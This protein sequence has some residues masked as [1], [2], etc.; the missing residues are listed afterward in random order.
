M[1]PWAPQRKKTGCLPFHLL[2]KKIESAVMTLDQPL[3]RLVLL[4]SD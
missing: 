2:A 1:T 4:E 3:K